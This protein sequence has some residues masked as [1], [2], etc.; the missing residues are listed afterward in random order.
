MVGAHSESD[1]GAMRRAA[2]GITAWREALAQG[3]TPEA[4]EE[5]GGSWPDGKSSRYMRIITV[6]TPFKITYT[7]QLSYA[8]VLLIFVCCSLHATAVIACAKSV[9]FTSFHSNSFFFFFSLIQ[10]PLRA[11]YVACV[12]QLELPQFTNG[13]PSLARSAVDS[14][15]AMVKVVRP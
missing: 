4:D 8:R 13:N 9:Q 15:V 5:H 3:R 11:A 6:Y 10:E 7:H 1:L 12:A 14:L 2:L